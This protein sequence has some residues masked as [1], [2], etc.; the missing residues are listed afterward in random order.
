MDPT[1][2][3]YVNK[4]WKGEILKFHIHTFDMYAKSVREYLKISAVIIAW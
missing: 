1:E 4:K 2:P 3:T